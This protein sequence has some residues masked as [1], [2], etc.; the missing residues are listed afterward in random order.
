MK[1]VAGDVDAY[2]AGGHIL[3]G[4]IDGNAKLKTGGGH[5]RAARINGTAHLETDGGNITMAKRDP[6]SRFAPPAAKLISGKSAAR[7]M[8]KR[9]AAEF[10]WFPSQVPWRW[11]PAGVA[12]ASRA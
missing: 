11:P 3:A 6:S 12:S 10:A 1:D 9:A 5:I 8:Q 7:S 2:T 4:N